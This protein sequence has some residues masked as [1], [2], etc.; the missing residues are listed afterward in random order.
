MAKRPD[1]LK[2]LRISNAPRSLAHE[3][4]AIEA[5][6]WSIGEGA[7]VTDEH[8]NISRMN[9]AALS[10]LG[11]EPDDVIGRWYPSVVIAEDEKG[12][13]IP[14]I[15]RPITE[16]FLTGRA[17][18]KK[19]YYCKKDGSR[20]PVA[21]TVSPVI[22]EGKPIGAIQVFRDIT[23]E[24]ELEKTKDEFISIASHQ[25]RT[26]AT[27]VKQYIG[28]MLEGYTGKL[29]QAQTKMLKV[30]YENNEHQ[31]DTVNHL[32]K[33]AQAD[34]NTMKINKE[35]VDL[36]SLLGLIVNEQQKSYKQKGLKLLF[37]HIVE[38]CSCHVDPLHIRMIVENLLDNAAKYNVA[39]KKVTIGLISS[40]RWAKVTI[41]DEGV[42]I[43][44][45]DIP[46]LFQ[47]FSRLNNPKAHTEGTGLG[48]YWVQK[49]VTLH[50]GTI[51][52]ESK[53]NIGTTF[54]IKLPKK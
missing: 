34:A 28:M 45:A 1:A 29:T 50:G 22:M 48:L 52:V 27:I 11:F 37:L 6:F 47:K 21:L 41:N 39:G 15:E 36:V 17:L 23:E 2:L 25:L 13:V 54:I 35:N 5:L 53:V 26:P 51:K 24:V 31:I 32:L 16:A 38:N 40:S 20:I 19:L 4:A 44:V 18:F 30:A 12:R 9:D 46:K 3:L 42:G 49:L 8:G 33:V 43:D 7:I 14:N 10:I